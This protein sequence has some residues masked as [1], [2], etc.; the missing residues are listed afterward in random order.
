MENVSS[1]LAEQLINADSAEA[2]L[3]AQPIGVDWKT[4]SALKQEVDRLIGADLRAASNL[5]DRVDQLATALGDPIS[6][7]FAEASRA[8]VLH[9]N[10]QYAEADSLY[11][12]AIRATRSAKLTIDTAVIQMHRVFAL[13]QMGRYDQALRTARMS[14]RVL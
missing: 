11:E 14:R 3:R 13:T 9:H 4:I 1:Q 2:F 5:S 7:G 12:N 6:K 10:G 8:R